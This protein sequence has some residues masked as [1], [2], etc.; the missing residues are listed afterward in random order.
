MLATEGT[1]DFAKNDMAMP[2]NSRKNTPLKRTRKNLRRAAENVSL[3]LHI[4]KPRQKMDADE[5]Q[6]IVTTFITNC[7]DPFFMV[8]DFK[9]DV[10]IS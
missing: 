5:I 3:E 8:R 7:N 1:K 4:L 9:F 6:K 2:S 10:N